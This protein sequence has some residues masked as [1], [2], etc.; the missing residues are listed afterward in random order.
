M[1]Q[2]LVEMAAVGLVRFRYS[3]PEDADP[4]ICNL[5]PF[6]VGRA[7]GGDKPSGTS[8]LA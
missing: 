2:R 4:R 1:V 8:G 3:P 6:P 5:F 7:P